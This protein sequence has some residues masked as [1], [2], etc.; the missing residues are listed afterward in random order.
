MIKTKEDLKF[1]L[2]QDKIASGIHLKRPRFLRDYIWKYLILFRKTE[3]YY[4]NNKKLLYLFYKF[5][6]GRLG[7]KNGG[8]AFPINAVGPGLSIAHYGTIIIN[9]NA[10]IGKNCR[11]HEG[12]TI[13][14]T[15][16]QTTAPKI[17]DDCF[18]GTGAK[19]IGDV[20]IGDGATVG[21]NSVVIKSFEEPNCVLVGV[22]AQKIKED[23]SRSNLN[24]ELFE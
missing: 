16:G 6:T 2:K 23:S 21:A 13:G 19:I 24:K 11:I 12:V 9:Q 17:G 8:F 4:N 7:R 1:Y 3:Y 22:P 5:R 18:I 10:V 14:S 15:N 20:V